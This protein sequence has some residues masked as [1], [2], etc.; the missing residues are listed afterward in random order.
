ML[1]NNLGFGGNVDNTKKLLKKLSD[2][3]KPEGQILTILL[4]VPDKKYVTVELRPVWKNKV[5]P[6][7]GW[8]NFNINFLSDLCQQLGFK[9]KVLHGNQHSSLIKIVK[10]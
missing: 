8:I 9:L 1:E 3:L 6:K 4:R 2:L 7:F 5:G 10:N